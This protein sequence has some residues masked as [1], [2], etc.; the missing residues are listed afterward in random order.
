ML[1]SQLTEAISAAVKGGYINV[2]I[3]DLQ[4]AR[5]LLA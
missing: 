1:T 5:E 2:L 3:T 4:T